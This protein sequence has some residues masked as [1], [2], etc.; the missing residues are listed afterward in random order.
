M[1]FYGLLFLQ[2]EG[3]VV[4]AQDAEFHLGLQGWVVLAV[5]VAKSE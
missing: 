4:V 3:I 1:Y 2:K 5:V